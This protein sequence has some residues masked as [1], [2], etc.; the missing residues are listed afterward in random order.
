MG[1]DGRLRDAIRVGAQAWELSPFDPMADPEHERPLRGGTVVEFDVR[2]LTVTFASTRT[3]R[4]R[5]AQVLVIDTLTLRLDELDPGTVLG[6][7]HRYYDNVRLAK[8][9][10]R[11]LSD[12]PGTS[13]DGFDQRVLGWVT[14]LGDRAT[15]TFDCGARTCHLFDLDPCDACADEAF[16]AGV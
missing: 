9:L 1:F 10:M 14:S 12:R 16:L 2:T 4:K 7:E 15:R 13:F 11:A 8:R 3:E 5:K 6:P